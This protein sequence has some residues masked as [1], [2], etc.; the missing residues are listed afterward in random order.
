MAWINKHRIISRWAVLILL[1]VAICGPW[2]YT[3]D[4]VPPPEWCRDP[5]ILLENGRCARRMSGFEIL[6]FVGG[7]LPGMAVWLVAE[8]APLAEKGRELLFAM[9]ISLLVLPFLSTL[10]LIWGEDTRRRQ[11]FYLISWGLA[12]ISALLVFIS[13][14]ALPTGQLWGIWLYITVAISALILEAVVL[15]ARRQLSL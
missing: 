8:E 4:G 14:S 15:I 9:W 3:S 6:A 1:M 7:L 2:T 12:T 13:T 10:L 5:N 11:G